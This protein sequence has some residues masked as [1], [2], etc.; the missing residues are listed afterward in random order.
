MLHNTTPDLQN[1]DQFLVWDRSCTKTD[2][3][4]LHH[5]LRVCLSVSGQVSV[6]AGS[7]NITII[8]IIIEIESCVV[9]HVGSGYVGWGSVDVVL[10]ATST[11]VAQHDDDDDDDDD[12][13]DNTDRD[14]YDKDDVDWSYIAHTRAQ[15]LGVSYE[16]LHHNS[17]IRPQFQLSSSHRLEKHRTTCNVQHTSMFMDDFNRKFSYHKQ[18]VRQLS[19]HKT[20]G[21]DTRPLAG[22]EWT[23]KKTLFIWNNRQKAMPLTCHKQ[24]VTHDNTR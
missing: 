7:I 6:V 16:Y 11:S 24:E 4:R 12:E 21:P 20:F 15:V 14:A 8:I 1:Q 3:L 2:G 17:S 13:D 5:R 9:H 22:E 10:L 23:C 19:R 18:I